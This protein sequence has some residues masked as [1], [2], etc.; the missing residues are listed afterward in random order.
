MGLVNLETYYSFPNID[1]MNN[2]LEY[3]SD[4]KTSWKIIEIPVG[5]YKKKALNAEIKRLTDS[6]SIE[7]KPNL[8]TLK[9]ILTI[10]V[11]I[12]LTLLWRIV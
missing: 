12:V 3:S 4:G 11:H 7:I 6:T 8:N 9:C 2:K 5:C 1:K 10:K